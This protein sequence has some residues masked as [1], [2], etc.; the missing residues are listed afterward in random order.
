[1]Y[2]I[3]IYKDAN[4]NQPIKDYLKELAASPDK[5][6][7]IKLNKIDYCLQVLREYGTRA[8]EPFV[9]HIEGD[10]WE[11]RPLSDR[12]FFFYWKYNTFVLLHHFV[13]KTQKTPRREIE[14]AKQNL[15]DFESRSAHEH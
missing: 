2:K 8:G 15:K 14:Q 11:L 6:S 10:I 1:M 5:N 13:K 9:E 12:F 3:K 4:G 7:R